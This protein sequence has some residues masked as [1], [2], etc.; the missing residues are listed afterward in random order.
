MSKRDGIKIGDRFG[1]LVVVSELGFVV[2]GKTSKRNRRIYECLC[3][4]GGT[5]QYNLGT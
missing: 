5:K 2:E 1:K 3:D 4:C